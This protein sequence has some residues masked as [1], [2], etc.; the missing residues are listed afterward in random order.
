MSRLGKAVGARYP[1]TVPH[2]IGLADCAIGAIFMHGKTGTARQP[3]A[4]GYA[5][6][7][8]AAH[9]AAPAVYDAP[10]N[11]QARKAVRI[12]APADGRGSNFADQWPLH[13][14]LELGAL[15]GAVPCARLHARQVFWEWQLT[16][17]SYSA[18]LL[19]SELVTNAIHISR[20]DARVV[21]VRLWLLADRARAMILVQD[22]S[23]VPPVRMSAGENDDN[24]RGLAVG[25]NL[26]AQWGVVFRGAPRQWQS[27]M[28]ADVPRMKVPSVGR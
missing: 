9:L 7:A 18:E 4:D 25:E 23:L 17:L 14:F 26:S 20:A 10:R 16:G 6:H 1:P 19:V 22:A 2:G 13:S 21:P 24:G 11:S 3:G 12:P 27:G 15:P 28:G 5:R 8:R